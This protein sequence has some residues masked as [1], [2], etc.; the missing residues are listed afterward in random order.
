M[1]GLC[2]DI[3][4]TC[5]RYGVTRNCC[6]WICVDFPNTESLSGDKMLLPSESIYNVCLC[7]LFSNP[8]FLLSLTYSTDIFV[9]NHPDNASSKTVLNPFFVVFNNFKVIWNGILPTNPTDLTT[10]YQELSSQVATIA[11]LISNHLCLLV[12]HSPS[13]MLPGQHRFW[14]IC[15]IITVAKKGRHYWESLLFW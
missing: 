14:I 8:K 7:Q 11:I 9:T 15:K 6:T 13:M 12:N 3:H 4:L 5:F 10:Y 1:T 2:E